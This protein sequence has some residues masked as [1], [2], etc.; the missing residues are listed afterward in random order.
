LRKSKVIIVDPFVAIVRLGGEDILSDQQLSSEALE[1][2][3]A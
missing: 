1:N 2:F 3:A